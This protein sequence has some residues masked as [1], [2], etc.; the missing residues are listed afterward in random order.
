LSGISMSEG[1]F[2]GMYIRESEFFEMFSEIKK[3]KSPLVRELKIS[4]KYVLCLAEPLK[5]MDEFLFL[6]RDI[7]IIK[8]IDKVKKNLVTNVSHELKTPLTSINGFAEILFESEKDEKRKHYL[9][10][11]LKNIKRMISIVN[12]LLDLSRLEEHPESVVK[13]NVN[14]IEICKQV[15]DIF[16]YKAEEKGIFLNFKAFDNNVNVYGDPYLLEQLVNNLVDNALKYTD[17]GGVS[18]SVKLEKDDVVLEVEDTG[19]GI[20][21]DKQEKIFERFYVVDKSR[22]RKSGGTGLGLSIV[23]HIVEIHNAKISVKSSPYEGSLFRVVFP[24]KSLY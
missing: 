3:T 16:K 5:E 9:E 21:E 13:N 17:R 14:L 15:I 22:S 7:E 10:I 12:D 18:V 4:N 20:P 24:G 19:I 23:K 1:N 11:I 8:N 2:F 6:F